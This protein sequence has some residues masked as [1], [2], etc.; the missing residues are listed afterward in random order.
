MLKSVSNTV[1]VDIY[2]LDSLMNT[3]GEMHLIKNI[4]GRIVKELRAAAGLSPASPWTCTRRSASLERKLNE[5]QEG[6]LEVRMVPIGQIFT[7]LSQV[8][9]KY[10]QDAGKEIDLQLS[11]RGDRARQA[12]D[13]RPC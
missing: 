11:G 12:H 5:L 4:I 2:K 9:R 6:I 7:R 10:A 13:R 1:R 3:V 8:V